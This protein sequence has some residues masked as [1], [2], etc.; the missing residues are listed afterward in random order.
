[1]S[2][3]N[4]YTAGKLLNFEYFSKHYNLIAIDISKH[5]E[6]KKPGLKQ[7]INFVGRLERNEGAK[8]FFIIE[9]TEKTTFNFSHN[10]V[11][12]I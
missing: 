8:M 5:T 2:Q 3:N 11:N 6:L 9:K 12:I 1:M 4:D 10:F 7:Q